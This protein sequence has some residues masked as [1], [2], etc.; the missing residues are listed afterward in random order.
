MFITLLTERFGVI[1]VIA[2][3]LRYEKSK[4]RYALQ[5]YS[6]A[7]VTL[8]RGKNNIW[9]LTTC[10]AKPEFLFSNLCEEKQYAVARIFLLIGKVITGESAD[11][12]LFE[13]VK[14]GL[15]A[16]TEETNETLFEAIET[17]LVYRMMHQLGYVG[18]TEHSK[19]FTVNSSDWGE[20][21]VL[22]LTKEKEQREVTREINGGLRES[23]LTR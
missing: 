2:S 13:I 6:Y 18:E 9:R 4:L 7:E 10:V 8:V 15:Q 23:Q 21:T 22:K 5:K 20:A 11:A 16:L 12:L 3:G 14:S 19:K 17:L 1:R